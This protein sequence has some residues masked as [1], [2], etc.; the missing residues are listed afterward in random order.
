M[1][2]SLSD[3]KKPEERITIEKNVELQKEIEGILIRNI[4]QKLTNLSQAENSIYVAINSCF[5]FFK[6]L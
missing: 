3:V 1:L 4:Y 2:F 6:C 5:S